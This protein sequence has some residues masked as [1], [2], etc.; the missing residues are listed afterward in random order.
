MADRGGF[1]GGCGDA[2]ILFFI[3]VFLLLFWCNTGPIC[4]PK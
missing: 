2:T 4:D 1:F 3:L